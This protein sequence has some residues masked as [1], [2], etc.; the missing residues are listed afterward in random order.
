MALASAGLT[1]AIQAMSF[2]FYGDSAPKL[3]HRLAEACPNIRVLKV[4]M[5]IVD[6]RIM[7]RSKQHNL[8]NARGMT[9]FASYVS[10]LE[11]LKTFEI[12]G[13]D[14]VHQVVSNQ[15]EPV[16]VDIN[17]PEA[18]GPWFLEMIKK[19]RKERE[20]PDWKAVKMARIEKERKDIA[21]KEA[22][23]VSRSKERNASFRMPGRGLYS[24]MRT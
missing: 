24:L 15:L 1:T 6:T 18:I 20:R 23:A 14:R 13:R 17:D 8:R 19:G 2:K 5:D 21:K 22:K 4:A 3:Y 7:S 11:K 16:L 12:S 10:G 9:A